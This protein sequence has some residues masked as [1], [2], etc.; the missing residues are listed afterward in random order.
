M[1]RDMATG[2]GGGHLHPRPVGEF[3]SVSEILGARTGRDSP[4]WD[5]FLPINIYIF[6]HLFLFYGC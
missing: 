5:G 3:F 1:G 4:I 2:W 6:F